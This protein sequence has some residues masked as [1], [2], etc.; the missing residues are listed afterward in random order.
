MVSF[1]LKQLFSFIIDQKDS[2]YFA[3]SLG[4]TTFFG[5]LAWIQWGQ[6]DKSEQPSSAY[7]I[8]GPAR[9]EHHEEHH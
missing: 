9:E 5:A 8:V 1:F 6:L 3:Y 4:L 2:T 7:S